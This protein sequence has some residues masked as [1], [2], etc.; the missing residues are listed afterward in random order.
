MKV[1][2]LSMEPWAAAIKLLVSVAAPPAPVQVPSQCPFVPSVTSVTN[3]NG[4][5]EMTPGAVVIMKF[6]LLLRKPHLGDSR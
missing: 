1:H 6:T 2:L 4:D 5:N 3:D